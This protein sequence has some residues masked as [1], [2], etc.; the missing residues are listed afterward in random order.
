MAA[1]QIVPE[2][3][4]G[5]SGAGQLD[6]IASRGPGTMVFMS[7][8][9]VDYTA[10]QRPARQL[11]AFG[12]GVYFVED[13]PNVPAGDRDTLP[14]EIKAVVRRCKGLLVYASDALVDEDSSWVCFEVGLAEMTDDHTARYTTTHRG[15]ALLSPLRDLDA[16]E[17][18]LP[19]WAQLVLTP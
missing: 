2:D 19:A 16:V 9:T 7:H 3:L 14:D 5:L 4:S 13:D 15:R 1:G 10:A 6:H 11:T 18:R 8:K 12:L 17:A